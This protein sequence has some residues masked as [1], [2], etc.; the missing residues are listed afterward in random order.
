MSL[1]TQL[2]VSNSESSH[3]FRF[4]GIETVVRS[5]GSQ[6]QGRFFMSEHLSMPPGFGSPYHTHQHEDEIFYVVEGEVAFVLDGA[7]TKAGP[8]TCVFGPRSI[9]HGFQVVGSSPA[10]MLLMTTPAKFEAFVNELAAPADAPPAPPDVGRL[11]EVASR[12]GIEIHGPL[13]PLPDS[14]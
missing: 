4:L 2:P 5:S 10:R 8:G 7:W 11:V 12:Y 1:S 9:A 6:T 13:P 14:L 3:V